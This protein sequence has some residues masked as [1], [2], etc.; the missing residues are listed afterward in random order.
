MQKLNGAQKKTQIH[1]DNGNPHNLQ[2][3]TNANPIDNTI[4]LNEQRFRERMVKEYSSKMRG[5]KTPHTM[6][7]ADE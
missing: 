6:Y 1:L 4:L 7:L 2:F 3:K 5:N